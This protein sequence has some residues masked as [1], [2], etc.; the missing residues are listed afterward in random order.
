MVV[1]D[2]HRL[3]SLDKQINKQNFRKNRTSRFVSTAS[4]GCWFGVPSSLPFFPETCAY[5][6]N[7][8]EVFDAQ[9]ACPC[10]RLF[11]RLPLWGALA[12][13]WVRFRLYLRLGLFTGW[14]CLR[15][16]DS[17]ILGRNTAFLRFI[18]RKSSRPILAWVRFR[19]YPGLSPFVGR[20]SFRGRLDSQIPRRTTAF[21]WFIEQKR[22]GPILKRKTNGDYESQREP[23]PETRRPA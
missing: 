8:H 4:A 16:L 9:V 15:G 13:A 7:G 2:S 5:M 6:L 11:C 18:E 12:F 17:Q 10:E 23:S 3:F 20:E 19:L 1:L 21:L 14:D 22:A